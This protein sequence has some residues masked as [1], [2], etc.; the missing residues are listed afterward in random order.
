LSASPPPR[1]SGGVYTQVW[2]GYSLAER[3]RRWNA[4]RAAA[5]SAGFD[6]IFV[7]LG[8]GV[9]ARYLTQFRASCVVLPADGQPA[10]VITDRGSRNTWLPEPRLTSRQ[11]A[12]PVAEA[13]LDAGFERARIGVAGLQGGTFAHVS[14]PQGVV[15]HSPFAHVLSRLPNARFEDATDVLGRVRYLKSA[16]EI[17]CLR[18]AAAIA[19][20][21]LEAL[22]E[23]ASAEP[24]I[25]QAR[26]LGRMLRLGSEYFPQ[27][28]FV[29]DGQV[30]AEINAVWGTQIAQVVRTVG[31]D[32][33]R[34]REAFEL[35]LEHMKPGIPFAQLVQAMSAFGAEPRLQG[36][37]A[38][39]DGPLL[40]GADDL[41]F[42][43]N[44]AFVWKPVAGGVSFGE[45]VLIT[46]QGAEPLGV[47]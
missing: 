44:T 46:A 21:G 24:A 4:V 18:R 32:D 1:R 9:D 5:A 25:L 13:L 19:R 23:H 33:R 22:M 37:G 47:F 28:L 16:E 40:P 12:E 38:G 36:L 43:A 2:D 26:I 29:R 15:S 41:S 6:C 42:E 31:A 3:D 14:S 20:A 7:P 35:G 8:N 39:D 34:A 30:R 10:I 17:E 27:W 45:P 11:W